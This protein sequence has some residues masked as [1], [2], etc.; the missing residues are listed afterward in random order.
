VTHAAIRFYRVSA[1]GF[2]KGHFYWRKRDAEQASAELRRLGAQPMIEELW[3][4]ALRKA[5]VCH[6]LNTW[7]KP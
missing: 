5:E 1:S 2:G 3:L 4:S 6:A 7:P